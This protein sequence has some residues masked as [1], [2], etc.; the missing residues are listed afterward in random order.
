M[1]AGAR[2]DRYAAGRKQSL[3]HGPGVTDI[4]GVE[5][6]IPVPSVSAALEAVE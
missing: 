3:E 6:T 4:T 5:I 1:A 2:L